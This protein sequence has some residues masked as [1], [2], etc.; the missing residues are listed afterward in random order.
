MGKKNK[1][2]KPPA[3]VW[4]AT[5]PARRLELIQVLEPAVDKAASQAVEWLHD[6]NH[7]PPESFIAFGAAA[8]SHFCGIVALF[9]DEQ[10]NRIVDHPETDM[11]L[12]LLGGGAPFIQTIFKERM[13]GPRS[14]LFLPGDEN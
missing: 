8:F 13:A 1:N 6:N 14:S 5:Y 7:Q 3:K 4:P 2:P 11:I 9:D 10:V 12:Y